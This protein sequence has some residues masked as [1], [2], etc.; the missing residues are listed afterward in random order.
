MMS[1]MRTEMK[2]ENNKLNTSLNEF[3]IEIK[4]EINVVKVEMNNEF[5]NIRSELK[6]RDVNMNRRLESMNE[7]MAEMKGEIIININKIRD[8]INE[9]DVYKRQHTTQML[10]HI[11]QFQ[12]SY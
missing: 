3:K 6:M 4:S 7:T 9:R 11:L 5:A 1:G 2:S 12:N 10:G 8:E